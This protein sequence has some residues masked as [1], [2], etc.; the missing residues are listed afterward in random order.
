IKL[1]IAFY[2]NI[3]ISG[4]I[5]G[6]YKEKAVYLYGASSKEYRNLMPNYAVQF[7]AIEMLKKL[8]IKE[9]D[10][11]GIPPIANKNHPLYGL[12]SFKTGFGGNIIHR[13]GCYDFT[14]KNFIYK[15]Y[16]NLEKLRYF[17]YKV[18][19]KKI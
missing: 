17:Y 2:N 6:I 11:L 1:I 12:F 10:L 8:E 5:V 7:K 18:I 9:Y 14:Y 13:I 3:I 15:I 19:R 4:I 16:A